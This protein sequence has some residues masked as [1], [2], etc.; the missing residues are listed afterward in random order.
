MVFTLFENWPIAALNSV[1]IRSEF[2]IRAHC[3]LSERKLNSAVVGP[4]HCE[5]HI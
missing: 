1:S 2:H 5:T 3:R 4:Q